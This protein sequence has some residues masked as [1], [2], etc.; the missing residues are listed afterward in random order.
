MKEI[1]E[2]SRVENVFIT[3][4]LFPSVEKCTINKNQMLFHDTG[5][6]NNSRLV[7]S[8][9]EEAK[10]KERFAVKVPMK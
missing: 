4:V 1:V 9:A 10:Q 8:K 6:L 2:K 5:Q 3:D 7:S